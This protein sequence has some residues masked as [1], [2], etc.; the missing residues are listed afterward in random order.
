MR[1]WIAILLA[2]ASTGTVGASGIDVILDVVQFKNDAKSVAWE[3][4]YAFPDTALTVATVGGI[5]MCEMRFRVRVYNVLTDTLTEEWLARV[6]APT[7][8]GSVRMLAGYKTFSL[9]PGQY[10]VDV[11]VYDQ[12]DT[13]R[14]FATTFS[15]VVQPQLDDV[16]LSDIMFVQAGMV[17]PVNADPRFVRNGLYCVPNPRHEF[18]GEDITV[19]VYAELYN[20]GLG[21]LDTF[22][23]EYRI[24][25]NIGRDIL[26]AREGGRAVDGGLVLRKDIPVAFVESG[27]YTL[28]VA[29]QSLDGTTTYSRREE[30]L[31]ILNP[32]MPPSQQLIMTEDEAFQA[33][34]WSTYL[35]ERLER[36][37]ELSDVLATLA[38]KELRAG[39]ISDRAKQKYL[40]RFWYQ[41][42]PDRSTDVNERLVDFRR[43]YEFA[44]KFYT[45][46]GNPN[47]WKTDRGRVLLKY[48]FPT[49]RQQYIQSI[50]TYPY[51]E[52]F[53][54]S[55]QG[56]VYFYFVDR[57][58]NSS[59]VLVHSTLQG[60]IRD[61]NWFERWARSH[62]SDPNSS[63]KG[64]DL[65]RR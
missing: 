10:A 61:D 37:L 45:S 49:Q 36:E 44:Q 1:L 31:F 53:F 55:L 7:V 26:V 4:H 64:Q 15:S 52:W 24:V 18:T 47:S 29:V 50:D 58:N 6:P 22:Q 9:E 65:F 57:Y 3:L 40:F 38:E 2:L 30:R 56:G 11:L 16:V 14:R 62:S 28:H 27:V 23:V 33:S 35:G 21:G 59:H 42:D 19:G 8:R 54:A 13:T 63:K 25:D 48:G 20:T 17:P 34:E 5:P 60:E 43:A 41:R 51:E 46:P 32:A 12:H 39:C